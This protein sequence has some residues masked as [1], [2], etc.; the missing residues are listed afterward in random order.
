MKESVREKEQMFLTSDK[1][2]DHF[3]QVRDPHD[4]LTFFLET[5]ASVGAMMVTKVL[6][7]LGLA[8]LT[9]AERKK[10]EG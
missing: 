6:L 2:L 8:L 3:H 4:C 1:I 10:Y 5:E 9:T 7:L